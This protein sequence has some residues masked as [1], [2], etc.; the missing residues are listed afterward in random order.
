MAHNANLSPSDIANQQKFILRPMGVMATGTGKSIA[1]APRIL[2]PLNRMLMNR[3]PFFNPAK[4]IMATHTEIID[5]SIELKPKVSC[6]WIVANNTAF[7]IQYPV[8]DKFLLL[9][10]KKLLLV[11]MANNT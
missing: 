6:M 2:F 3:M 8:N 4:T 11:F 7:G 5:L 9:R 10:I 1:L